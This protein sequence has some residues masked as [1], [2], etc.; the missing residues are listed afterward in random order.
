MKYLFLSALFILFK[1][2]YKIGRIGKRY[3]HLAISAIVVVTA[4]MLVGFKAIILAIPLFII[5]MFPE[6]THKKYTD[7][8]FHEHND[9]MKYH[10]NSNSRNYSKS[11]MTVEEAYSI[12]DITKNAS[13]DEISKK[14]KELMRAHHPDK[15]GN[16]Y[17]A[18]K[19]N[20]AYEVLCSV[21]QH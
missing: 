10:Y 7:N 6:K 1:H 8:N 17:F 14:Y 13:K 3:Y 21:N 18:S 4:I 11:D 9:D 2:F 12:F 5:Y 16:N 15:G 20:K 19:I